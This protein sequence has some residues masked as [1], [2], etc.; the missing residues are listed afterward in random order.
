MHKMHYQGTLPF[1]CAA[2]GCRKGFTYKHLLQGHMVCDTG[3]KQ[4]ECATCLKEFAN[5]YN[6]AKHIKK[7]SGSL[8]STSQQLGTTA[9]GKTNIARGNRQRM[10]GGRH[11]WSTLTWQYRE[12]NGRAS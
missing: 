10:I 7:C 12:G 5:T 1:Q 8:T 6:L 4:E 9:R 3:T 2:V 11:V